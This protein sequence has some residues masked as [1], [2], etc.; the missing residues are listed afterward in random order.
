VAQY[1]GPLGN[2]SRLNEEEKKAERETLCHGHLAHA[3]HFWTAPLTSRCFPAS[4]M[5]ADLN[6]GKGGKD[7]GHDWISGRFRWLG[8]D[9]EKTDPDLVTIDP[10]QFATAERPAGRRKNQEEFL[11]TDALDPV[12]DR[13]FGSARSDI[14]HHATLGPGAVDRNHLNVNTAGKFDAITLPSL[15]THRHN[16]TT[17]SRSSA[18]TF[19]QQ[20]IAE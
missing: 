15:N 5:N 14:E 12:N 11:E 9:F 18:A 2:V 1:W 3:A 7:C 19:K 13:Q 8:P 4:C 16:R 6:D 10:G 17:N 20:F